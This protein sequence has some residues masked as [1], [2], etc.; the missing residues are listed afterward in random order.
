ML[1]ATPF[2]K[3]KIFV[4]TVVIVCG[5][6]MGI[7]AGA[8]SAEPQQGYPVGG[9]GDAWLQNQPSSLG[10]NNGYDAH[11]QTYLV[12]G[13]PTYRVPADPRFQSGLP[14]SR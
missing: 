13:N 3:R 2:K 4:A 8:V 1:K 12:P 7:L 9:L 11:T 10:I 5:L 14:H 6:N